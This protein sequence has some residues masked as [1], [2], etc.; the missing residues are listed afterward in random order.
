MAE[1]PILWHACSS[2]AKKVE[3]WTEFYNTLV[4]E[5]PNQ[6][7]PADIRECVQIESRSSGEAFW[8]EDVFFIIS[9]GQ[10]DSVED[11][12]RASLEAWLEEIA[13]VLLN[14]LQGDEEYVGTMRLD[15]PDALWP[16]SWRA[17]PGRSCCSRVAAAND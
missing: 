17:W 4:R 13:K 5:K 8:S 9:F 11:D 15:N 7:S 1:L 3:Y 2:L 16:D 12:V 14:D 10:E 6:L